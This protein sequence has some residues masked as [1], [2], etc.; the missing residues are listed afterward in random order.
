MEQTIRHLITFDHS[1]ILNYPTVM[2]ST[3]PMFVSAQYGIYTAAHP[4]TAENP[5][6]DVRILPKSLYGK[7]AKVEEAP[8]SFFS[9]H[10][11]SSWHAD[12]A[13][14]ITFLG[15]SG[16]NL[17]WLGFIVLAIGM[18]R[19]CF[20][21][22][23][24]GR[25]RSLRRRLAS[26][27]VD[28]LLPRRIS[29]RG[30]NITLDIITPASNGSAS[31]TTN[32]SPTSTEP[33]SPT[34]RVPLLPY[35]LVDSSQSLAAGAIRRAGAWACAK[36]PT[37]SNGRPSHSRHGWGSGS[38][39]LFFLPAIFTPTTG[40]SS[41]TRAGASRSTS[42]RRNSKARSPIE[43]IEV[44]HGP[45]A[46]SSTAPPPPYVEG[47]SDSRDPNGRRTGSTSGV[48][49]WFNMSSDE[50]WTDWSQPRSSS[51]SSNSLSGPEH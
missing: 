50:E 33:S 47:T 45:T 28:L 42:A 44:G 21:T 51:S 4:P 11:G 12:D 27:R 41:H 8:N 13:A 5:G 15:R 20:Q 35:N 38:G 49:R 37:E 26:A 10:Y 32:T 25:G 18:L 24:S 3:G 22:H 36:P 6:G 17:M 46:S 2:F 16:M 34:S 23:R 29:S 9:H 30:G 40:A 19:V 14:L 48:N 7:N 1:W 39:T 43:D 31:T